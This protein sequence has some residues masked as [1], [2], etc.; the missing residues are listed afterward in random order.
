MSFDGIVA[1]AVVHELESSVVGGRLAKIYQPGESEL[2][3][4]IR[5]QGKN[6]RLLVSAHPA[7]PRIHR[8]QERRDNPLT[9]PM[10]C[11]LL[12][13]YCEGGII[14]QVQQVDLERVIHIDIRT[15]DELGF[16]VIRRLVV[17]IMGRHSNIVL[18][19]P[20]DGKIL[21]GIRRVTPAMSRHRQVVPGALYQPPPEQNKKNPLKAD[22]EEFLRS[23]DFN[24]GKLDKQLIQRFSGLGP[25]TAKEIIHRGGIG[26]R[27]RLWEAFSQVMERVKNHQYQPNVVYHRKASFSAIR[28][29]HLSG[30][31]ETFPTISQCLE[32]FFHG[33]AERDRSRQ[34]N[35][36]LIRLLKNAIDKNKKKIEKLKKEWA[37]TEDA[38]VHRIRGELVTA[39]MHEIN[40]GDETLTAVNYYDPEAP[41]ITIPLDSR[42]TPSE[43]AQRYFKR[44]NKAKSARKWNREQIDKTQQETEYLES[45]LVQL[46]NAT[47]QE[48][49]QIK[50]ELREEGWLRSKPQNRKRKRPERPEPTSFTSSEGVTILVGKNNKQNDWLTHRI[51]SPTDT[52]LHTKEIPG[53]HVVIRGKNF[54]E[55]TLHEA[56]ILAAYYSKGRD[57]SRVPVDYTL[58]KHVKKPSGARPGFVTYEGQKTLFP[59]PDEYTVRKLAGQ[60]EESEG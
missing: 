35:H 60:R 14:E 18:I 19:D 7:Y 13:K 4:H 12:R 34:Q 40:R 44:Y 26:S 55:T 38:D 37:E 39:F 43:N 25:L 15:R 48:A 33:K 42:L 47:G 22:R 8:T 29:T 6:Q 53:S 51:A 28:L 2:I 5:A 24:R 9:P 23:I 36:D 10:F 54:S 20:A 17:E 49:E 3:L 31:N 30:E 56:A 11:M 16:E 58:I 52:W 46:E 27:E 1:R 41:E 50:E 32:S 45:V 57:S 21:D 59:T